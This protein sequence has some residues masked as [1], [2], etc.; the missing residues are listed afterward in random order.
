MILL[1]LPYGQ[2]SAQSTAAAIAATAAATML[3]HA[4][5]VLSMSGVIAFISG[6]CDFMSPSC[7][8][9][10]RLSIPPHDIPP[11]PERHGLR[12][13][14]SRHRCLISLALY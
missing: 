12:A 11:P 8:L 9:T 7:G 3:W 5:G 4:A 6:I 2:N 13:D 14:N 1:A 10:Y